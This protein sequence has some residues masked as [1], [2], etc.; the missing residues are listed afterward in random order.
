MTFS[1]QVLSKLSAM[2]LCL[3]L[4]ACQTMGSVGTNID[5]KEVTCKAFSVIYWSKLDTRATQDQ[6]TV[7]NKKY[8]TLCGKPT[9]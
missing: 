4:I 1:K 5:T 3:P 2:L 9:K 6:I 8:V 7:H